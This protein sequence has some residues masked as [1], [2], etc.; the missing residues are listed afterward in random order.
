MS[1]FFLIIA[2][3]NLGACATNA[4]PHDYEGLNEAAV[5]K[6]FGYPVDR[7]T[8]ADNVVVLVFRTRLGG[9][10][11][12]TLVGDEVER[13]QHDRNFSLLRLIPIVIN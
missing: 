6:R 10:R 2:V 11:F 4:I 13:V 5:I 1:R 12:V 7:R 9:E 8:V 3:F